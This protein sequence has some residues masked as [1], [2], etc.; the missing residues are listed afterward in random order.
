M[1]SGDHPAATTALRAMFTR[2]FVYL[3][4]SALQVV[5][6]A[7]MTPI[8]TRLVSVGEFGQLALAI[9]VAQLLAVTFSFGLPFAAQKVF[10]EEDG[11][12]R[13]CG[14]LA[15]SA[16]LAGAATLVVVLAAPGWGPLVGLD[17]I[18]DARLAALWAG[19]FALTLTALAVLRSRD[20][21]RM[22]ILLGALQSVG[23]QG[24]GLA[25]LRWWTPTATSYLWGLVI[26]QGAA[27]LTGL[28]VLRPDWSA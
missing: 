9:V 12:R 14:T 8:L 4:A 19:C 2:D 17:R 6:A 23:A 21:L 7:L 26:G 10:A 16:V 13:S 15:I 27:A 3:G 1:T 24:I 22:A 25:L 5:L 20:K 11:D 28:L 18:R